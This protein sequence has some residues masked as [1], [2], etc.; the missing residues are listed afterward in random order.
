MEQRNSLLKM[1]KE[2]LTTYLEKSI[3]SNFSNCNIRIFVP[4]HPHLY[5]IA[6]KLKIKA[7]KTFIIKNFDI[8]SN[9]G[10]TKNLK[11]EVFPKVQGLVGE[12]YKKDSIVY[13]DELKSTN[14]INY[15]LNSFQIIKTSSLQWS[16]CCPIHDTESNIV[17][18]IA[19]DGD[20]KIK[21]KPE[22]EQELSEQLFVFSTMLYENVPQL[23]RR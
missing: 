8:L 7:R 16:I 9:E 6:T 19:L 20:K 12:C 23:F 21:I 1:N 18:I 22:K 4:K 2:Y 3:S 11:F 17:A 13:D 15:E 5:K 14:S 10:V